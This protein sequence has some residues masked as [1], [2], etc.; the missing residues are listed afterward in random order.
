MV[1]KNK[2][3][4]GLKLEIAYMNVA[5][6]RWPLMETIVTNEWDRLWGEL[7]MLCEEFV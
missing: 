1:V 2:S 3:C 4:F 6:P 7:D 5:L